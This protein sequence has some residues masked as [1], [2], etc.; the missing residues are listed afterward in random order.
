MSDF[1]AYYYD[2]QLRDYIVQ[3]GAV[4]AGMQVSIGANEDNEERLISIPIKNASVDRVV[5][6]I[7]GDNTQ[8]KP[9]RLPMFSFTLA[10]IGLAPERFKG[11]GVTR[12]NAYVPTGGLVPDDIKVVVQRQPV[13]YNV[14]FELRLWASNQDQNY[15]VVEQILSMFN[16]DI[17]IQT[18]DDVFDHTRITQVE[19]KDFSLDE[20]MPAGTERRAIVSLFTFEVPIWLTIPS[21]VHDKVIKEI[22]LRIGT[23]SANAKTN[24]EIIADLDSQGIPYQQIFD[25]ND[26][27]PF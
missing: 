12:R 17:Q 9:L 8:N 7:M 25:G 10:N 2:N 20:T 14:T 11:I 15:Q 3:F 18:S 27:D 19:L 1:E 26:I 5:G 4:F 22:Y 13:P 16:P 23:V 24:Y 6:H 21:E